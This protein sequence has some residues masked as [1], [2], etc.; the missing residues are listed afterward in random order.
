MPDELSAV[1]SAPGPSPPYHA[2]TMTAGKARRNVTP[3]PRIGAIPWRRT[4]AIAVM[5]AAKP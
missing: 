3:G 2:E 5:R 4:M 1:E